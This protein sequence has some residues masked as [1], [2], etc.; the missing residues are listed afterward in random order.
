MEEI[1]KT[2]TAKPDCDGLPTWPDSC[3]GF[4]NVPINGKSVNKNK[5]SK[6][7]VL[8]QRKVFSELAKLDRCLLDNPSAQE[9]SNRIYDLMWNAETEGK[10]R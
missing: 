4:T 5:Y 3:G 8:L 9:I 7:G 10:K 1:C 2:C 6:I